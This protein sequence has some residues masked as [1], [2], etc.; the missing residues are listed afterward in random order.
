LVEDAISDELIDAV[1]DLGQQ[2]RHLRRVLLMAFRQ[3]GGDNPTLRIHADVQFLPASVRLL[4]VLLAVP[5][6][7][8]ADLQAA[9]VNDQG[10][11]GFRRLSDLLSDRH[12]GIA[13]QQRRV[14]RT[15]KR[16][17]YQGQDGMEEAFRLP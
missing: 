2:S 1:I 4:P 6:A 7:L 13:S 15:G 17:I 10:D 11:R 14:I 3:R 5:F 16:H 8:T 12:R 9:T